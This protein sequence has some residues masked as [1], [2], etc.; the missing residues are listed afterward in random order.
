VIAAK[1]MASRAVQQRD[2][3]QLLARVAGGDE[4]AFAALVARYQH[5]FY[6]VARRMLGDDGEAQDAVQ[7]TFLR[8]FR[9]AADYRDQWRTST[10]LYRI[11]T[12]VCV[13]HWRKRRRLP[14]A[15][16]TREEPASHACA[17]ER[18]DV[19]RA[20]A[21]LPPE[22]RLILILCYVEELSYADIAK[23]RG[24]SINTVKTQL[25]RAKRAMRKFLG[26]NNEV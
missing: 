14:L 1:G 22:A 2:E 9:H 12:N 21:K 6:A 17:A 11:L 4:D 8:V 5:R 26:A 20:L 25:L 23:A 3:S 10:W 19:D 16:Q 7:T 13:D 18:M 24:I 15:D